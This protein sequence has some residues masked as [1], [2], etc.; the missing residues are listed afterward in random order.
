MI[1]IKGD[2]FASNHGIDGLKI[3]ASN[4]VIR[5]LAINQFPHAFAGGFTGGATIPGSVTLWIRA[6]I[7]P[8]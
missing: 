2:N 3:Q 7:P 8:A 6:G 5:G 4:C 1:E